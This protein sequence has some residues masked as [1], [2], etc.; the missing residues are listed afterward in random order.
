MSLKKTRNPF[1]EQ[2]IKEPE[3]GK[4]ETAAVPQFLVEKDDGKVVGELE[5]L[6]WKGWTK[7]IESTAEERTWYDRACCPHVL[8]GWI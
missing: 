5:E 7:Q 3:W 4:V 1:E 6:G 2:S 8:S